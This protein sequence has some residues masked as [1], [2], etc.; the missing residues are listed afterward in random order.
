MSDLP[1]P[2]GHPRSNRRWIYVQRRWIHTQR[3]WIHTRSESMCKAIRFVK[4]YD[5]TGIISMF[6]NTIII[7]IIN[8]NIIIIII[9]THGVGGSTHR[10]RLPE[11]KLEEAKWGLA[12]I[13]S[14]LSIASIDRE[15]TGS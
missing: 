10:A 12:S 15:L 11:G 8:I 1:P 13:D 9:F 14:E 7:N 5:L 2:P 6:I 3:R 4:Q